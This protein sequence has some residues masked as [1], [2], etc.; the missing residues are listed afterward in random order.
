[1]ACTPSRYLWAWRTLGRKLAEGRGRAV[2]AEVPSGQE[3]WGFL[4][5]LHSTLL[6]AGAV[7]R[8]VRVLQ[9]DSS[10]CQEGCQVQAIG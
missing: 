10:P 7:T 8:E 5:W 1:M 2:L 4:V 9:P 3:P 6:L